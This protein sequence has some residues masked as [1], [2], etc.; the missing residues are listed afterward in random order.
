MQTYWDQLKQAIKVIDTDIELEVQETTNKFELQKTITCDQGNRRF[1]IPYNTPSS[2]EKALMKYLKERTVTKN[3]F[4][5]LL[6]DTESE[7]LFNLLMQNDI[8]YKK[9]IY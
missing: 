7:K 8:L 4:A 6:S 1:T 5:N 3:D 9:G 2:L